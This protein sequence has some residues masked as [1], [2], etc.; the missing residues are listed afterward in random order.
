MTSPTTR[1]ERAVHDK[2][3]VDPAKLADPDVLSRYLA[4]GVP[5]GAR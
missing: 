5:D 1:P 2:D 3:A 4:G